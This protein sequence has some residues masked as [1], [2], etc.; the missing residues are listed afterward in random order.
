MQAMHADMVAERDGLLQELRLATGVRRNEIE[1]Q[2]KQKEETLNRKNDELKALREETSA[3]RK[4]KQPGVL[5]Q[6]FR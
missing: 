3:I 2:L 6:A 4:A 5:W 1:E